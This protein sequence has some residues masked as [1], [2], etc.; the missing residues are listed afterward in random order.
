[1]VVLAIIMILSAVVITSQ[2]SFNKTLILA[3]TAYDIA[4]TI[5]SAQS[6]GIGS[7]NRMSAINTGY[8]VH[9]QEGNS[10][11]L[12]ADSLPSAVCDRPD[13]NP[14]NY[15]YEGDEGDG[16]F[17]NTY[18]LGN[19]ITIDDFCVDESC[20]HSSLDIVFV[21]PNPDAFIH[22]DG[23]DAASYGRACLVVVSPQGGERYV[24]ISK[25]GQ[26]V[27]NAPSCP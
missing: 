10:F 1:M 21:R 8:G 18:T 20:D 19:G 15:L 11:T 7:R 13:C 24:S 3:N 22:V 16:E 17:V 2:G 6:F 26:I 12:F 14:G 5:R 9:I 23:S 25:S 27:A 4:L